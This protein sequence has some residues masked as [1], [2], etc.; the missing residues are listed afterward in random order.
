MNVVSVVQLRAMA[1]E[2]HPNTRAL[3]PSTTT[4]YTIERTE[5]RPV[6]RDG[7][8]TGYFNVVISS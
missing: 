2:M 7:N 6:T 4:R 8:E 5:I 3:K 1:N